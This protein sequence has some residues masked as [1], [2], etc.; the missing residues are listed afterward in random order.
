MQGYRG[1]AQTAEAGGRRPE[2]GGTTPNT[3]HFPRGEGAPMEDVPGE[4]GR[5][6]HVYYVNES[7]ALAAVKR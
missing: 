2:P 3:T 5:S 6:L 7:C 1:G 4:T